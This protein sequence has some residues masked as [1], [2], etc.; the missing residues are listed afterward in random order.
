MTRSREMTTKTATISLNILTR[1]SRIAHSHRL[2]SRHLW[3]VHLEKQPASLNLSRRLSF[4]RTQ[5]DLSWVPLSTKFIQLFRNIFFVSDSTGQP[6]QQLSAWKHKGYN[7]KDVALRFASFLHFL[8]A[9]IMLTFRR[10]AS[11]ILGQAFR[12]SPENAFLYI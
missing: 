8:L 10:R 1:T 5:G 11:C 4:F 6:S 7:A 3:R 12:Y 9:S 2:Q